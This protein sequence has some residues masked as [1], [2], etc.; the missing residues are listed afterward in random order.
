MNEQD[1][2]LE[3]KEIPTGQEPLVGQINMDE[4]LTELR[5]W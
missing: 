3:V 1:K 2:E 5:F 4:L